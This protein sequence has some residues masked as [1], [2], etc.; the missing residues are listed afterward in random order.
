MN[1]D[2]TKQRKLDPHRALAAAVIVRHIEDM[3]S[4]I[5]WHIGYGDLVN[6]TY[7]KEWLDLLDIDHAKFI[8]SALCYWREQGRRMAGLTIKQTIRKRDKYH[9]MWKLAKEAKMKEGLRKTYLFYKNKSDRMSLVF[10]QME[11]WVNGDW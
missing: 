10:N 7:N 8:H 3:R 2:V 1:F 9:K 11:G 4:D 5:F 6:G